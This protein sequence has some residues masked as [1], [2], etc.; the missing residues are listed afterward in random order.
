[1]P[2]SVTVKVIKAIVIQLPSGNDRLYL[3][4]EAEVP[5]PK[6]DIPPK[7]EFECAGRTGH[8]WCKKNLGIVPE[9]IEA[10]DV[11][12]GGIGKDFHKIIDDIGSPAKRLKPSFR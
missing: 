10:R 7:L 3:Y 12:T 6:K 4:F 2:V 9:V 1:M 8:I 5:F 11:N